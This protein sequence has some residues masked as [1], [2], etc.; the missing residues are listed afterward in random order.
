MQRDAAAIIGRFSSAV[1]QQSASGGRNQEQGITLADIEGGQL[2]FP[3]REMRRKRRS[4]DEDC[5]G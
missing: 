2:N 3:F 4:G 1:D 5:Q